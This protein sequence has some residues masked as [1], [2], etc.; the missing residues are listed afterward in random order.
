MKAL[1][2]RQPWAWAI[3]HGGKTI[4]NRPRRTQFRGTVAI[5]ASLQPHHNWDVPA[6]SPK[7]PPQDELPFGAIVGFVD[8]VDCVEDHRSKWFT[9]PFGY[10]LANPRPLKNPVPCKGMLGF[11]EVPPEILPRCRT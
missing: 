4:E 9:G 6:R 8:I 2:V 1:S 7:P 3:I 11:W 5:H 10:V